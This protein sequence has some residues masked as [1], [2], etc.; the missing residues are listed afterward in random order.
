MVCNV[1]EECRCFAYTGE[2][3]NFVACVKDQK[4]YRVRRLVVQV[5]VLMTGPGN[6]S[7]T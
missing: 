7:D 5:G 3:D 4:F 2:K 6:H 1:I